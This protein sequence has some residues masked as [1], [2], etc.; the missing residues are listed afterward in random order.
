MEVNALELVM[1]ALRRH[2]FPKKKKKDGIIMHATQTHTHTH[3][4]SFCFL[5]N[6]DTYVLS[7]VL[8]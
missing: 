6:Q 4:Y 7:L 8:L 2:S 3:I 5:Y 1:M